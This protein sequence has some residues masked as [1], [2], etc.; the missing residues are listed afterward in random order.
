MK[1]RTIRVIC[2]QLPSIIKKKGTEELGANH[3]GEHHEVAWYARQRGIS[4]DT[5][6]A[7]LKRQHDKTAS[8]IL[9]ELLGFSDQSAFGKFF[10]RECGVS[11]LQYRKDTS[12]S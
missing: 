1:I 7:Q 11:P 6:S 4:S 10:K 9:S 8:S 2:G 5:L 3:T 12:S